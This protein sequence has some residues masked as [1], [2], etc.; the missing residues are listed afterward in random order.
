MKTL[1]L[2]STFLISFTTIQASE[3][4][5]NYLEKLY[6]KDQ[7]LCFKRSENIM[8]LFSKQV[9]PYYFAM[10]IRT[11]E[12][13]TAKTGK[14]RGT[15]ML[16][17]IDYAKYFEAHADKELK[18][19]VHWD[20]IQPFLFELAG[21]VRENLQAEHLSSNVR[22]LDEKWKSY[23]KT[24]LKPE[25]KEEQEELAELNSVVRDAEPVSNE[26][27]ET[28]TTN[29]TVASFNGMPK[30]TENV[31]S[32]SIQNEKELLVMINKERKRQKI[33]T[34]VWNA[35]LS[36]ACRYHAMDMGAQGYFDHNSFDNIGGRPKEVG[37][38]FDR[39]RAFYHDSFVNS[40]NI[41]AGNESAAGTYNQWYNSKGHYANMF[42]PSSKYVGIGV[43]KVP[44]SE[45]EYYWVFCTA[46]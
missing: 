30:G 27:T 39:I 34:L 5:F 18:E 3:W 46:E 43:V 36:R 38:T 31:A 9:S 8:N 14:L 32:Y 40:E 23:A 45:Y 1:V 19:R 35:D 4:S 44:N 15:R 16:K 37:E 11:E 41:A 17:V 24:S 6:K 7:K 26:E 29:Y 10:R 25:I 28:K 2:I 13:Y 22:S 12:V 33:D 20:T 42:N 21:D